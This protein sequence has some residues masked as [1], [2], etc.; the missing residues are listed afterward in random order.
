[1]FA[2]G[3]AAAIP[4]RSARIAAKAAAAAAAPT[5]VEDVE[6]DV[7]KV[8]RPIVAPMAAVPPK[9]SAVTPELMKAMFTEVM[10]IRDALLAARTREAMTATLPAIDSAWRKAMTVYESSMDPM[11]LSDIKHN[12]G[13]STMPLDEKHAYAVD[14]ANAFL[15]TAK[16]PDG[17]YTSE[18]IATIRSEPTLQERVK[19]DTRAA[20]AALQPAER[21]KDLFRR[22][23]IAEAM[24][25]MENIY[26]SRYRV[27][28]M[29][30]VVDMLYRLHG[31]AASLTA[32]G[33][34]MPIIERMIR[35][36]ETKGI[37]ACCPELE[38]FMRAFCRHDEI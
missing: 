33:M 23:K 28:N 37:N 27:E 14:A 18:E 2:N 31:Y 5:T 34:E 13:W 4:R 36:N 6:I 16:I 32:P 30:R 24:Y 7:P 9:P 21:E 3:S 20:V 19:A 26:E 17:I 29:R 15:T 10:A 1:M 22:K 25:E 8:T 35:E 38:D 11:F 12:I